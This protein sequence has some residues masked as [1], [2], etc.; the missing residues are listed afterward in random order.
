MPP[1]RKV[2]GGL[3]TKKG[4]SR[5][6]RSTTKKSKA[7]D[8]E[9]DPSVSS[10]DEKSFDKDK[11]LS[12]MR[13]N[14]DELL[15]EPRFDHPELISIIDPAVSTGVI[16][17]CFFLFLCN[18][19]VVYIL[20]FCVNFRTTKEDRKTLYNVL[21]L[22]FSNTAMEDLIKSPSLVRQID[23][24]DNHWPD[25]L[26]QRYITFNK[27]G[28]YTPHHTYPKV[29]NNYEFHGAQ[30]LLSYNHIHYHFS[31]CLM[32]VERCYT[33]FHIDFG[34]TSVWYHVLKGTKEFVRNP[35]QTGFFGNVVDKCARIVLKPGFTMIIPAGLFNI[36]SFDFLHL[37]IFIYLFLYDYIGKLWKEKG[38]HYKTVS[39]CKYILEINSINYADYMSGG[40]Q[41]TESEIPPEGQNDSQDPGSITVIAMHAENSL[42]YGDHGLEEEADDDEHTEDENQTNNDSPVDKGKVLEDVNES[43]DPM[44]YYHEASVRLLLYQLLLLYWN[45]IIAMNGRIFY[46]QLKSSLFIYI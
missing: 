15:N 12:V 28:H 31:Y 29:Q 14:F 25:G 39:C 2:R 38:G 27:K 26:R 40:I 46:N 17:A 36:C 37:L 11:L 10:D 16:L 42:L 6:T 30:E 43:P 22:E 18:N 5:T 3:L 13:Y 23:W 41:L 8:S 4:E 21:S 20:L 34:G 19:F 44:V 32:S 1:K 33:D 24:V 9:S 35:D 45:F 7:N